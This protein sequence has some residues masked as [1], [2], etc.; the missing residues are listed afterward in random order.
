MAPGLIVQLPAVKPLS[1][2]L[3]VANAHVGCVIVPTVGAAGVIG[4]ALI[5]TLAEADEVHPAALVTVKLWVPVAS[6]LIVVLAVFPVMAPGLIVQLPAGKPLSTTLPVATAQVGCVIA[7]T[8]GAAGVTGWALITTLA[9]ADEVHPA[10]LVTVKLWVPVASVLIVVLAVFPVMAPG[11]IV[12]LPAGKPLSTTLPVATAQVG[13]VIAPT[14][15]AAG[16]T[17][18]ALITTLA[19]ADEVHPAALV[20][21][22]LW[23]PVASVL[24][25]VLAVFPVMAPGLTVQLPAGKPLS[26][27]LP[28]ATAQV[29]C[30]I[31]PTVGAAGVAGWAL[32]TTLAE[33][34]EVHPAALVTVKLWVPVASVLIVV[35]AVLPA[36]APGL[37]VQLPAGKPLSTTLPVA[38]AHVGCVIVPTVGATGLIGWAL[39]TTLA[40]AGEVHP[41]ALVT[42]KL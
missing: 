11:L 32:I 34:D 28:V 4:W 19:E 30:V 23:V 25:V 37:I 6:V 29:G 26:T 33:A 14:V 12:Q 36:M 38:N 16:V 2:T 39:I 40:E 21:V 8:V 15:G 27:T 35:L 18:W 31:A 13:C 42:V 20:T 10:A 22:K 17:G 41:A 5:T 24:I 1:T 7:P 3:P 9:E